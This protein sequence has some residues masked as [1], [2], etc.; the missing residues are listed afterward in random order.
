LFVAVGAGH[1]GGPEGV[2]ALLKAKGFTVG[3]LTPPKP[4][5]PPAAARPGLPF[6]PSSLRD[7]A[8]PEALFCIPGGR[9]PDER[10][11]D[12]TIGAKP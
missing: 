9:G 3:P 11:C 10:K 12:L 7:A 1:F 2:L 4:P 6:S 8:S 5:P